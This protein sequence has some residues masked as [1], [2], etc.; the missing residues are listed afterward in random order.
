VLALIDIEIF[1]VASEAGGIA[2]LQGVQERV[3]EQRAVGKK[4]QT[5]GA[6]I[7][8]EGSR[9]RDKAG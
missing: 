9:P 4:T 5:H 1:A 3:A 6:T 7:Q 2:R 8:T